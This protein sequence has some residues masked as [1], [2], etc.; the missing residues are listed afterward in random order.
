MR[1][2]RDSGQFLGGLGM[3]SAGN[4][5]LLEGWGCTKD[6]AV[7]RVSRMYVSCVVS[8]RLMEVS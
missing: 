2:G 3:I 7:D 8:R 6:E 1:Y 4:D 5:A